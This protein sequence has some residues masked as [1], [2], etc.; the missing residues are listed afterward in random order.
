MP[1]CLRVK[2]NANCIQSCSIS[3]LRAQ[4]TPA[5]AEAEEPL[6]LVSDGRAIL[7]D[8]D[9]KSALVALPDYQQVALGGTHRSLVVG[10]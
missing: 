3:H 8:D 6:H 2:V 10:K 9:E 7:N 4:K 5:G 1:N